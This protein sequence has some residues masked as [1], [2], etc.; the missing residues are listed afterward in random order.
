MNT[1]Q[2][3]GMARP[4]AHAGDARR[5]LHG[6][7]RFATNDDVAAAFERV[8]QLLE[9]APGRESSTTPYRVLAYLNAAAFAR[10]DEVD[11]LELGGREDEAALEALPTIGESLAG[12]I[13]EMALYDRFALLDRLE[14]GRDPLAAYA[15]L[16]GVG[17]VLAQR[18]VKELNITTLEELE[19]AARDG[20]LAT[21]E[22][23]GSQRID[24]LVKALTVALSRHP[25]RSA[26][27]RPSIDT[28]LT[29]DER[30]RTLGRHG[31]LHKIAPKRFNPDGSAWLPILQ[32][33]MDGWH[34]DVMFSNTWRAHQLG[35][36]DDWV[37]VRYRGPSGA[38]GT[39]TVVTEHR[40]A[41]A[42]RRVVR[43]RE[44][45]SHTYHVAHPPEPQ[46]FP[47]PAFMAG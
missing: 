8:A 14:A 16:P 41:D 42:G 46:R 9:T 35:H 39:A 18:I 31:H 17:E 3:S 23:M 30:Y 29:I 44:R 19:Q 7:P 13:I 45:D 34:F 27:E 21:V 12:L 32:E 1:A 25:K 15:A 4:T 22:G 36:C 6:T 28:L 38:T 10:E 37:V 26:A 20:R 24:G 2:M 47:L 43:G 11:L 5:Q 33:E 40:G